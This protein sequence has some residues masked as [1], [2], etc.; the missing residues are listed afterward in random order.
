MPTMLLLPG[1]GIGPEV[2]AEVRRV[3]ERVAPDLTIETRLFGGVSYDELGTPLT[4]EALR[5]PRLPMRC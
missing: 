1:D 2:T 3:A 5:W 4:E